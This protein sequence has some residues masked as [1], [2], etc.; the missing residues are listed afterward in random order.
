METIGRYA[1]HA[2]TQL[3]FDQA[4]ARVR[5]LLAQQG[6]GVLSEID[7]QGTLRDKLGVET[8]PYRILGACNP[9]FAHRAIEAEPHA[10][11]MLP[12]NLVVW[13]EGDHRV[14]TAIEPKVLGQ[15]IDSPAVLRVA[16]EV[17][18]RMRWVVE[19]VG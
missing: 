4:L 19:N 1:L 11:V 17:S 2:D 13:D 6:F 10:G 5:E 7:V 15:V 16:Q 3:P 18:S 14:V 9:A 12:C 8:R